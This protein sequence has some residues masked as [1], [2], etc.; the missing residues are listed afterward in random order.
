M[1]KNSFTFGCNLQWHWIPPASCWCFDDKRSM[2]FGVTFE[3]TVP[4]VVHLI[5]Y[6]MPT[7]RGQS[8]PKVD[9]P[10]FTV[11][12]FNRPLRC[13][14]SKWTRTYAAI[15]CDVYFSFFAIDFVL[16][17]Q[18]QLL[19]LQQHL[20]LL[21]NGQSPVDG[22][23]CLALTV[24]VIMIKYF[25]FLQYFLLRNEI[26]N[27]TVVQHKFCLSY[28]F[29]TSMYISYSYLFLLDPKNCLTVG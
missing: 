4:N 28:S 14:L 11:N 13:L 27:L 19:Q 25:L 1:H 18:H 15:L 8:P 20:Q 17:P 26:I 9:L 5:W 2:F 16:F 29:P 10:N 3:S 24:V 22:I 6:A 12:V 23:F 7:F 21:R